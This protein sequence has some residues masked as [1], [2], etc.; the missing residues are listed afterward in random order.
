M[1]LMHKLAEK[2]EELFSVLKQARVNK[3][4]KL[5]VIASEDLNITNEDITVI[6]NFDKQDF[7]FLL[8][9]KTML[10]DGKIE[11]DK[12]IPKIINIIEEN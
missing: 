12:V 1:I 6:N 8:A 7:V 5:V 11:C 10:P 4:L 9:I 2:I 3:P